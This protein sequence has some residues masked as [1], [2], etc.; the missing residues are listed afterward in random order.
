MLEKYIV[1]CTPLVK[2]KCNNH[3]VDCETER[4]VSY[5]ILIFIFISYFHLL[6]L[7]YV[8]V[9]AAN[10]QRPQAQRSFW[11]SIND[12]GVLISL[13]SAVVPQRDFGDDAAALV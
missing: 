9:K 3:I 5:F 6:I 2:I 8:T 7:I 12:K 13:R 10:K 4:R 1:L 11:V